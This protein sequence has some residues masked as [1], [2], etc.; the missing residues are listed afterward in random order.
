[1]QFLTVLLPGKDGCQTS[2]PIHF[3]TTKW[4]DGSKWT[5]TDARRDS[6]DQKWS[7]P[8]FRMLHV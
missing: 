3:L 1:M 2:G 8:A 7:G 4:S 5:I 6:M